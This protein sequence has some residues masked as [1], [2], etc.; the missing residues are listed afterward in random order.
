MNMRFVRQCALFL[1]VALLLAAVA[2]CSK[3]LSGKYEA[4]KFP[5][6]IHFKGDGKADVTI[7]G[8]TQQGTYSE[9]GK[10]VTVTVEKESHPLTINDDGS[11]SAEEHGEKLTLKKKS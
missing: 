6:T 11:L 10:K 1:S 9:D 5:M 4:D 2:G 3:K 8:Q 7:M